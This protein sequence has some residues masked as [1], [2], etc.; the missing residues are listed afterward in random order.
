VDARQPVKKSIPLI[1]FLISIMLTNYASAAGVILSERYFSGGKYAASYTACVAFVGG[2]T[3]QCYW[4]STYY[5]FWRSSVIDDAGTGYNYHYYHAGAPA[6]TPNEAYDAATWTEVNGEYFPPEPLTC[7]S[8]FVPDAAGENCT[9]CASGE[10]DDLSGSCLQIADTCGGMSTFDQVTNQVTSCETLSCGNITGS[11]LYDPSFS[12]CQGYA[13]SCASQGGTYGAVGGSESTGHVCLT[14]SSMPECSAVSLFDD[15]TGVY[16]AACTSK[17]V[18]NNICDTTKY[19]CDGDGAIDDQNLDGCLDNGISNGSCVGTTTGAAPPSTPA[20]NVGDKPFETA[21]SGAGQCDPTSKNYAEC[22]GLVSAETSQANTDG[23]QG[24]Q[25]AIEAGQEA[26]NEEIDTELFTEDQ[27]SQIG[28]EFS[29]RLASVPLIMALNQS[30]TFSGVAAC[31]SPSF[32]V[33]GNTFL[34]NYHCTL[35]DSISSILGA[36]MIAL[37]SIAGLR[38]IMSA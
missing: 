25:D 36:L 29:A 34:I 6:N 5:G 9:T 23:L 30:T 2:D 33:L 21:S 35:Y 12:F 37:Y 32:S 31:P 20:R 28:D 14:A 18:P 11:L 13:D 15:G 22:A 24:I 19:D 26:L 4:T 1:A 16:G 38:H 27:G 10:W 3:Y 17:T 8:P 7:D